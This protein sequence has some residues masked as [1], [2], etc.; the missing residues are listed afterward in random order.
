MRLIVTSSIVA[1]VIAS[2]IVIGVAVVPPRYIERTQLKWVEFGL[3]SAFLVI[4]ELRAY[5]KL[6]KSI[7]FWCVFLGMLFV[8]LTGL[9]YF[10]YA[11]NGVSMVTFALTGGVEFACMAIVIY[12]LL[13][14]GP[15]TVN[16]DL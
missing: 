5:W 4:Y 7:S 6:R 11:G 13:D 9:G 2:V 10:F 15:A 16:L 14:A 1:M 12:W 3:V 8:Y